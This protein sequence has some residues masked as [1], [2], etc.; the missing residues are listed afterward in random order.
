MGTADRTRRL[1]RHYRRYIMSNKNIRVLL[2]IL[3]V[4]LILTSV[5]YVIDGTNGSA[6]GL[7]AAGVLIIVA[8]RED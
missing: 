7:A 5:G 6:I 2:T 4:I 3:G 1:I 8:N